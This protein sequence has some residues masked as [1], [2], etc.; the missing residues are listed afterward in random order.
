MGRMV[1]D[2]KQ[3]LDERSDP[4]G[5]PHVTTEAEGRRTFGE[6]QPEAL[7]L[8]ANLGYRPVDG[9]GIYACAPGAVFLGKELPASAGVVEEGSTWAS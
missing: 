4:F 2:V 3:V 9:Y 1:R 5:R 6:L 8:Y 7:A